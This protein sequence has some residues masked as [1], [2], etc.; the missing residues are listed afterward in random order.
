MTLRASMAGITSS[1]LLM[2]G[3]AS[4]GGDKAASAECERVQVIATD[5]L[6]SGTQSLR[7][8]EAVDQ[9]GRRL[10]DQADAIRADVE[11]AKAVGDFDKGFRLLPQLETIADGLDEVQAERDS[12][13]R[14][15]DEQLSR[16][17]IAVDEEP[18]CFT[19]DERI[20]SET[21]KRRLQELR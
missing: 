1:V 15:A 20:E 13:V 9:E 2:T 21:M 11:R 19:V 3:A 17:A 12:L 10:V 14:E 4:C 7:Q 8:I 16:A 18:D 5:A 6:E